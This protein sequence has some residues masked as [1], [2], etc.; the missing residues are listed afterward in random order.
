V[1]VAVH[2]ISYEGPAALALQ[3]APLLADAEGIELKASQPPERRDDPAGTV[4]LG[5][6]V[7]GTTDA[8][9]DAIRL[10]QDGLPPEATIEVDEPAS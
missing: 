1:R 4:V 7:E 3:V 2:R 5:L 8:V 9:T 6:T 10:I